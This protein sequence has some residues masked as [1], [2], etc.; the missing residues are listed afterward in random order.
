MKKLLF[1]LFA[2][3]A[4]LAGQAQVSAQAMKPVV[5]VSLAGY[6][7]L[8]SDVDFVGQITGIP[9]LSAQMAEEGLKQVTQGQGLKGLDKKKPWGGVLLSD[10]G[11][12]FKFLVFV[13]VSDVKGLIEVFTGPFGFTAK[14]VGNGVLEVQGPA[15]QSGFAK[16][17]GAYT[18]FAQN[19]ADLADLPK[20]PEALLAGLNKEYDFAVR[21]FVQNVPQV[22]RDQILGGLRMG[23]QF[24]L[25]QQNPGEDP[26][27]FALRKQLVEQQLTQM[28]TLFKELDTF[29]VGAKIDGAA[30]TANLDIGV[31]VAAGSEM[32]KQLAK[33]GDVQTDHAGFLLP[34]AAVNMTAVG[35][36]SPQEIEQA[37]T[38]IKSLGE[39]AKNEIDKDSSFPDAKTRDTAKEIL[40]DLIDVVTKTVATGKIDFGATV[41]LAPESATI[42]AGGTVADGATVE[43]ALK[44]FVEMA[45]SELP[46]VKLNA[47]K[48]DGITLHTMSI[49]IPEANVQKAFG[50]TADLVV[51]IGAKSVH[52]AF[53]RNA[54]EALKKVV[55]HS[56]AN[57]AKTVPPFQMIA[58]L[59]PILTFANSV[60]PNPDVANVVQTL[61][62]APGKDHVSLVAEIAKNGILYRLKAEEGV[63]RA[64]GAGVRTAIPVGAG[65]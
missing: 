62:A 18:F 45:Q 48:L 15:P 20:D 23:M 31:T 4:F 52:L 53:G 25:Q 17:Q 54:T 5:V 36:V 51:G 12:G 33:I 27:A 7:E 42:V 24:S 26:Q 56:T 19:A 59:T 65:F 39:Q 1:S 50:E 63:L 61:S 60:E 2:L 3:V 22:F 46:E 37:N 35:V 38:M 30:K 21:A 14:D 58:S 43:S 11:F 32:A 57:T 41:L 6:D 64:I 29:T 9:M 40:A 34:D 13:P 28:E 16:T 8:M 47:G 10:G 44:K 55:D 49:P